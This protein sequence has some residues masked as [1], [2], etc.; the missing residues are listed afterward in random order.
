MPGGPEMLERH[1]CSSLANLDPPDC[2]RCRFSCGLLSVTMV[3]VDGWFH[4]S[5]AVSPGSFDCPLMSLR[6]QRGNL[7]AVSTN[8]VASS[9]LTATFRYSNGPAVAPG[10]LRLSIRSDLPVHPE[11]VEGCPLAPGRARRQPTTLVSGTLVSAD[12]TAAGAGRRDRYRVAGSGRGIVDASYARPGLPTPRA[13]RRPWNGPAAASRTPPVRAW[14]SLMRRALP[15]SAASP[16]WRTARW[17]ASP[18][19]EAGR[20]IRNCRKRG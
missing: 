19:R 17:N 2:S 16:Q 15:G 4:K 3:T 5:P 1:W 13:S 18:F 9:T 10:V 20:R 14:F 11:L 7:V 12:H 8:A 6:A